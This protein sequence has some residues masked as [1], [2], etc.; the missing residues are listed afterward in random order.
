[1][2]TPKFL[3]QW[4]HSLGT[5]C[6]PHNESLFDAEQSISTEEPEMNALDYQ[7]V[8]TT[9]KVLLYWR[10]LHH[11][12]GTLCVPHNESLFDHGTEH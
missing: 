5:L 7:K 4:D 11:P 9:H 8:C 2:Y 6:V 3:L 12:L 10:P 1:M